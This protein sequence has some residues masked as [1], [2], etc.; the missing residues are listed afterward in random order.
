MLSRRSHLS[1]AFALLAVVAG[2]SFVQAADEK[3]QSSAAAH[4]RVKQVLGTTVNIEGDVAV[5]TVDDIVFD[6][7]GYVEY[8][9]VLNK[10]KLVTIPWEAAKFNFEKRTAM[11]NINPDKFHKIPTYTV[12]QYPVF[13]TPTYR[14]QT[15]QYY[16]LTPG[17]AR[18]LERKLP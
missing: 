7:N 14:T 13:S 2:T 8:L 6:D 9:I 18:R 10:G 5:G 12:D 3:P 11:V 15:Y 17:Q 1:S 4:Y 16:G